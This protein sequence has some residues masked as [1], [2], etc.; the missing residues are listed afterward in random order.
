[1]TDGS[2]GIATDQPKR[3]R[4]RPRVNIDP[5]QVADAVAELFAQGGE[6][7]VGIP[8]TAE[9]LGVSRATLY[10]T[11]PTR[12][13]LMGVL[14]E[15]STRELTDAALSILDRVD[16]P[17]EQLTALID[18]LVHDAV[19]MRRYMPVFFGGGDLPADVVS[20]WRAFAHSFEDLW[21]HVVRKAMDE[22]A[23]D[24]DDPVITARLLIG[25]C[26]WVSR[27]YRPSGPYGAEQIAAAA[28]KLL[29]LRV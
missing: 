20:R 4:G 8:E 27:W 26:I 3:T 22:G 1:M 29:P 23:L 13:H 10:R 7:A 25:Q 15:R 16:T 18:L 6:E 14:F 24:Q 17:G 9:K 5:D 28:R 11:Y 19:R 2:Q 12:E 21:V